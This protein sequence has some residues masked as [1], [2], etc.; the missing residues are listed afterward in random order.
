MEGRRVMGGI[1]VSKSCTL[2]IMYSLLYVSYNSITL[3]KNKCSYRK[4][5][6]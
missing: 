2:K 4:S 5:F 1:H 3:F 6:Q